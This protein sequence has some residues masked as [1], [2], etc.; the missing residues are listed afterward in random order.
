MS[1]GSNEVAVPSSS[2]KKPKPK[3]V[4]TVD[5]E[6][7]EVSDGSNEVAAPLTS[8]KRPKP[9]SMGSVDVVDMSDGSDEVPMPLRKNLRRKSVAARKK[10]NVAAINKAKGVCDDRVKNLGAKSFL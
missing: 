2:R 3:S 4:G 1:N 8:R 10:S 5:I 6:E 7:G 9:R